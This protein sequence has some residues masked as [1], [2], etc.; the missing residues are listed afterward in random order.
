MPQ[1]KK[2]LRHNPTPEFFVVICR[3]HPLWL[4]A[5]ELARR[6]GWSRVQRWMENHPAFT[7]QT[8]TLKVVRPHIAEN[9]AIAWSFYVANPHE[10]PDGW[11]QDVR[12][13]K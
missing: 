13:I 6:L 9:G 10:V 12:P 7:T 4:S 11:P 2:A 5:W 3:L 1:S 8:G